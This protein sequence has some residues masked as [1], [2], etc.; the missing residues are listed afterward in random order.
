ME[1][2]AILDG[3]EANKNEQRFNV[4]HISPH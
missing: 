2:N 3:E 1:G 4:E